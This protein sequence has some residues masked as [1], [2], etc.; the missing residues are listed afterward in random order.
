MPW[1]STLPTVA[2]GAEEPASKLQTM[3]SVLAALTDP[4]T[5][6]TPTLTAVITNPTLGTGSSVSGAY[7][8]I[9]KLVIARFR[10]AFGTSGV[11]AGSG[12]YQISLPVASLI[13]SLTTVIGSGLITDASGA[14]GHVITCTPNSS[15]VTWLQG[16]ITGNGV[17]TG[18]APWTWAASDEILG[19]LMYEAA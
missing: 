4:W 3:L 14:T 11:V 10:I 16:N 15:T 8:Q 17:V 18:T 5:S 2:A 9:G 19:Q 13:T 6:W 7:I 1:S 12:A